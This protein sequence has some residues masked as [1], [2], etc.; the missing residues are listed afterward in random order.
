M[1]HPS[2]LSRKSMKKGKIKIDF[3]YDSLTVGGNK[4]KLES[5]NPPHHLLPLS[6][7]LE[8]GSEAA[9]FAVEDKD[10]KRVSSKLHRQFGHPTADKLI[11]LMKN[12]DCNNE[13]LKNAI[14]DVTKSVP[15]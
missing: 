5:T 10:D 1:W 7:W 9:M 8:S 13:M 11:T 12:S 6:F 3:G 14:I 4:I 2:Y 15:G